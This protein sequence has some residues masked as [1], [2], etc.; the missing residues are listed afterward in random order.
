[1]AVRRNYPLIAVCALVGVGVA[2]A[3][4]YVLRPAPPPDLL[5]VTVGETVAP[6]TAQQFDD[7]RKVQVRLVVSETQA[8][9]ARAT[10]TVTASSCVEGGDVSSGTVGFRIDDRAVIY[11]HTTVPLFRDIVLSDQGADVWALQ[12]ELIRLGHLPAESADGTYGPQTSSAVQAL[13]Q[14]VGA[15]KGEG[16]AMRSE[17]V[18]LPSSVVPRVSCAVTVGQQVGDGTTLVSTDR[19]VRGLQVTAMP[20]NLTPGGRTLSVDGVTGPV[21][22]AGAADDPQFLA[23]LAEGETLAALLQEPEATT[24]ATLA[25][26]EPLAAYAVP[27]GSIIE[28]GDRTCVQSGEQIMRIEPLGSALGAAVVTFADGTAPNEVSIGSAITKATCE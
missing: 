22:E 21:S 16:V 5:S 28:A 23:S 7:A 4:G 12:N 13:R 9:V 20:E 2:A 14:S 15:G 11:L 1:M 19:A 3:L 17:F 24:T 25:L 6:V 8:L 27:V 18:W 10:G 26:A